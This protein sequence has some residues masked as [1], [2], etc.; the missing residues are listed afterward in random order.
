MC[1]VVLV[2]CFEQFHHAGPFPFNIATLLFEVV[3]NSASKAVFVHLAD[4][5]KDVAGLGT[6][7]I[8][9]FEELLKAD[10]MGT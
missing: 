1:I 6:P 3:T 4:V 9:L 2:C 8:P 5:V 7:F 10:P